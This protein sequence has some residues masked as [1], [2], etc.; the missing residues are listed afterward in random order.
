MDPVDVPEVVAI[1]QER[2]NPIAQESFHRREKLPLRAES[3]G[4]GTASTEGKRDE[5]VRRGRDPAENGTGLQV[6]EAAAPKV[7][8][9]TER[10][11]DVGILGPAAGLHESVP[12]QP[13]LNL[14]KKQT[15]NSPVHAEPEPSVNL[16]GWTYSPEATIM[17]P[18]I[19][20][21]WIGEDTIKVTASDMYLN[22]K[23]GAD[24]SM[25][26]PSVRNQREDVDRKLTPESQIKCNEATNIHGSDQ[27]V[28]RQLPPN[29]PTDSE[30]VQLLAEK[31]D[32]RPEPLFTSFAHLVDYAHRN[33]VNA[34]VQMLRVCHRTVSM[35]HKYDRH[36]GHDLIPN[37]TEN[38]TFTFDNQL[39]QIVRERGPVHGRSG[40]G[41]YTSTRS[42]G[43]VTS[44]ARSVT[45]DRKPFSIR[46]FL[47]GMSMKPPD[48][49]SPAAARQCAGVGLDG[50]TLVRT[51]DALDERHSSER[52]QVAI[53]P[54]WTQQTGPHSLI[55]DSVSSLNVK[56]IYPKPHLNIQ[57]RHEQ[58]K[59]SPV[60]LKFRTY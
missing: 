50:G 33:N 55:V 1:S 32:W 16:D 11:Y 59:D 14:T 56:E 24:D 27:R 43:V 6:V 60:Q 5:E 38:M 47:C 7:K 21:V 45:A 4:S 29:L 18:S 17:R 3:Y 8:G 41:G 44:P 9:R 15:P 52:Q 53:V 35:I 39:C 22:K 10:S 20:V 28:Y 19:N 36:P 30:G 23:N 54:S 13:S 37:G 51:A 49:S 31:S 42:T 25:Q 46:L 34:S 2:I 57:T 26:S 48:A 12:K 40:R 58:K